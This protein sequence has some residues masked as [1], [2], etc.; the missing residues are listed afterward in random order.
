M[1]TVLD[2][3]R[4]INAYPVPLRAIT[5]RAERRGLCLDTEATQDVL[6]SREYRL[7][8]ADMLVWLS[9]APNVSQGGQ[10]YSFSEY[11]RKQYRNAAFAVYDELGEPFQSGVTY[12][13]KGS[14]L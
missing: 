8:E 3:L 4:G 12:G 2:A 11:E 1:A 10:S 9:C 14:R 5:A 6:G 13:Y 7:A